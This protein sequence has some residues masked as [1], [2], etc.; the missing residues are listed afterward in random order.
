MSSSCHEATRS[1]SRLT[2]LVMMT[3]YHRIRSLTLALSSLCEPGPARAMS[4]VQNLDHITPNWEEYFVSI[5]PHNR[6]TDGRVRG[7]SRGKR[8]S[9]YAADG[10]VYRGGN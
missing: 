8:S 2:V 7:R 4:D 1:S 5:A 3:V 6:H 9:S 10:R